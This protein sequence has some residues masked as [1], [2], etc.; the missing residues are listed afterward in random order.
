[1][2]FW[3]GGG[4]AK[5]AGLALAFDLAELFCGGLVGLGSELAGQATVAPTRGAAS[6][7]GE[8]LGRDVGVGVLGR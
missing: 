6:L 3:S 7:L 5:L 2:G 8:G 4:G 1:M